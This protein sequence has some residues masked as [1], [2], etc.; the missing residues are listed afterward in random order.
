[1][2]IDS[3][4]IYLAFSNQVLHL[5]VLPTEACNFRCVYCYED[6]KYKRMEPWV[7]EAIKA[8]LNRRAPGLR[9]LCI[10][11]FG[12][13]PLL[14]SDIIMDVMRHAQA[15]QAS[16]PGMDVEAAATTNGFLLD[17][18]ML[19][20]IVPLGV[21]RFQITFDGPR[22]VHDKKR[23]RIGGRGTYDRIW[24]NLILAR[25]SEH[26]VRILV[27]LHV[28]REDARA[29]PSFIDD[30]ASEFR[31]D[32]RFE[33]YIRGLSRL[34]GPNDSSLPVLE[35]AEARD[36]IEGLRD[37]A[38]ATGIRIALGE[39]P[40]CYAARASSFVV[41]ANGRLNKCTV[42]LE[43]PRNQVGSLL[44]DGT[45]DIQTETMLGWMRGFQSGAPGELKCPMKG[46]AEGS[47][48][49]AGVSSLALRVATASPS[50]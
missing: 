44:A 32:P 2:S 6:F 14:A 21:R 47:P 26:D 27:R 9:S 15:L 45:M 43:H 23:I 40:V 4:E 29:I 38:R 22:E 48:A 7:V 13:E 3:R 39:D 37:H 30:Y 35:G 46:H 33:L 12:G 11:W 8:L 17:R 20:R 24:S 28:D 25:Q 36:V 10:S 34:G 1:M 41:R 50:P 49:A 31:A 42:A 18:S 19:D 16:H 5:I